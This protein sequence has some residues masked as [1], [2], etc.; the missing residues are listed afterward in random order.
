MNKKLLVQEE[1]A[2]RRGPRGRALVTVGCQA[3]RAARELGH[4]VGQ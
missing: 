4:S 1:G 2:E 3:G